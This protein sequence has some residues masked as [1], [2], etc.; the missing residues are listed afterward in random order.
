LEEFVLTR[1]VRARGYKAM[2][3]QDHGKASE[4]VYCAERERLRDLF[5]DA[6]HDLAELQCLQTNAVLGNDPDFM[7]F[8]ELIQ[9][10]RRVKDVAKYALVGHMENHCH[11]KPFIEA[12]IIYPTAACRY[13]QPEEVGRFAFKS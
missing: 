8:D 10:A 12:G 11:R 1:E 5:L 9:R 4:V 2:R 6:V 3:H 13:E 7:R